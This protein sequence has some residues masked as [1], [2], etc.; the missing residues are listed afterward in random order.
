MIL[1]RDGLRLDFHAAQPEV[2]VREASGVARQFIGPRHKFAGDRE[3]AYARLVA[4]GGLFRQAF[5]LE[6]KRGSRYSPQAA[7]T[8]DALEGKIEFDRP[9]RGLCVSVE[10][11]N[12]GLLFM[13]FRRDRQGGYDAV[14]L[15]LWLAGS[16]A[17]GA[18]MAWNRYYAAIFA[19]SKAVS[20]E[21]E[22]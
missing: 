18:C 1:R 21:N 20:N 15:H 9:P 4:P 16:A 13:K 6:S 3:E 19:D 10:N 8:G 2:C 17:R 12:H 11:L 5:L 14:A 7:A 22:N